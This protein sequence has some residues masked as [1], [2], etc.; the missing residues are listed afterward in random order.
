MYSFAR[1]GASHGLTVFAKSN[2]VMRR[3]CALGALCALSCAAQ[4]FSIS[5]IAGNG[6]FGYSGDGGPA[7]AAQFHPYCVAT[8]AQGN[9]YISDWSNDVVRKVAP[10]GVIT[11]VAGNGSIGYSGDGGPAISAQLANP[12][13]LT[14]D[15]QG[16]MYIADSANNV[17]REVSPAGNI[18]TIAGTN[19]RG[20]APNAVLASAAEFYSPTG[21]VIDSSG[22]L[23][24]TDSGNNLMQE[25]TS[26]LGLL[27]FAGLQEPGYGGDGG[28]AAAAHFYY[29]KGLAIDSRGNMYIADMA[30]NVIRKIAASGTISTVAGNGTQ[31]FSGDNGPATSAQL[32]S[33]LSVAV[34]AA[35]NLY[36]ADTGNQ[37]IREVTVAG[38]ITTIAGNGTRG[39][40]GDG[41]A[42]TSAQ[43]Y[44]P[45]GVAVNPAGL[46][47]VADSE[48]NVIRLLTP[49]G[50]PLKSDAKQASQ[51]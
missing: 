10:N 17:I 15:A 42:G 32:Y 4:Q 22:N 46:V 1:D 9:F 11:T 51:Q 31:G 18:A 49:V 21:I 43:L 47:Y 30:N 24:I 27:T 39:Y 14:F 28:P 25:V 20:F 36:I 34:D 7:T 33:P 2:R 3:L 8:D 38:T 48:N 50:T 41:G 35:G 26:G 44:N 19:T 5:S 13:G 29:P 6:T 23:Y 40:S 16:D 37:R 45:T 12:C